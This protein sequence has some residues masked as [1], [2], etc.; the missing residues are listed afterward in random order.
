MGVFDAAEDRKGEGGN[1]D[2][3]RSGASVRDGD[4]FQ[5]RTCGLF[6]H[7]F[8]IAFISGAGGEGFLDAFFGI[9]HCPVDFPFGFFHDAVDIIFVF[10]IEAYCGGEYGEEDDDDDDSSG[11]GFC[12]D[13]FL[14]FEDLIDP[15][16]GVNGIFGAFF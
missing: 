4:L 14:V 16:D 9:L 12:V 2:P 10:V 5:Q 3:S 7:F 15:F 8:A 6:D 1:E 13:F 11:S